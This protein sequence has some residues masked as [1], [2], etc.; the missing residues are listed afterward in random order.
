[1][2]ERSLAAEGF[3]VRTAVDGGA[4][5]SLAEASVPDLIVL[6]V[7]MPGLGGIDVCR[8]LRDKGLTC[9]I[10][11]LTA[12]DGI[13]DRV[14]G[15][16]AGADDYVVKPFAIDE[17]I[18]RLGALTRRGTDRSD[19]LS[20]SDLTLDTST[21]TVRRGGQG[22]IEVTTR[23]RQLLELLL[24]DPRAVVSRELAI[25]AIWNGGAVE[26]IVDRYIARLRDKLGSPPLIRTVR[27]VGFILDG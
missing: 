18:A 6:D 10:L 11:M 14:R 19:R 7:T 12:R 4:A 23:E 26:N 16:E 25:E 5:L 17:V 20:F 15:L 8:R 13:E 22:P 3:D 27:G 21:N 1:M 24:R 2:L 9:G